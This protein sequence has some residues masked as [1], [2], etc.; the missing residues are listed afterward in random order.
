MGLSSPQVAPVR[1]K[2]DHR[3]FLAFPYRHYRKDPHWVAP[4]RIAQKEMFDTAKHPFWAHAELQCFLARGSAG[5][6]GRIAAI[7]DRN[8]NEFHQEAAGFFGFLE[9]VNDPEVAQGLLEAAARWLRERGARVLRG[10]LN[11][12]TNYECGLLVDGFDSDPWVMMPYNP[13]YYGELI[14]RA[15]WRRAKDLYAWYLN[16]E[17][18][19]LSKVERVAARAMKASELSVRPMRMRDFQAEAALAWEIY[20]SAWSRN[21]GFAP[22]SRD[23]FLHLA[24]EMKPL[25]NP[26]LLLFA[27]VGGKAVGFVLAL[28]D[29]NRALKP[30]RGRLFPLGLLK[31]MYHKRT[32]RGMR[33]LTLGVLEQYRTAGVAAALY[34]EIIRRGIQQGFWEAEMSWV[35]EDN[36]LMNRSLE[37]LSARRY[38]TYRIYEWSPDDAH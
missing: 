38:K 8:Y 34:A 29:L 18:V 37:A 36:V 33:V 31:I 16:T 11:P 6:L 7:I 19:T 30:A 17:I 3:E 4:L 25:A 1:N 27:E 10:P 23:E 35:L 32:I 9:T 21:W 28:P 12:S 22:M 24:G 13:P 26:E 15:G 20:S 14:E 5:T 2:E